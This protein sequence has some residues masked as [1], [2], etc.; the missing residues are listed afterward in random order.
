MRYTL[1]NKKMPVVDLDIDE[2]TLYS[3][4]E[5]ME[6]FNSN[7]KIILSKLLEKRVG[8]LKTLQKEVGRS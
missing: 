8:N 3:K 2:Q 4:N 7:R 1:M 6:G 5:E